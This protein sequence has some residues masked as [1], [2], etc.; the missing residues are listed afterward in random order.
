[1]RHFVAYYQNHIAA[2]GTFF[3]SDHSV[4]LH[5]LATKTIFTRKGI[6]TALTLYM[7][8]QAKKLGFQHCFL[9]SSEDGFNLYRKIGFKVYSTT[10]IYSKL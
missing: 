2:A 8:E 3:I 1:M 6:G 10:Q 7:M 4:M 9:D 5:N